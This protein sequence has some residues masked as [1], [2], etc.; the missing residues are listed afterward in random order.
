MLDAYKKEKGPWNE[1]EREFLGL[2]ADRKIEACLDRGLFA[3]PATLLCSEP[4]PEH[5]HR[6]LV[7]DYLREKWEDVHVTHL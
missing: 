7:T 3:V 5:C 2:M 6:R 1:Y 4:T